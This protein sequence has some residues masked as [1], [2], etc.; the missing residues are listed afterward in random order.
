MD[1]V[2]KKI[3]EF[4]NVNFL[5]IGFAPSS[6]GAGEKVRGKGCGT[7]RSKGGRPVTTPPDGYVCRRCGV[8]G[9]FI[10]H[11]PTNGD[12]NYDVKVA[13]LPTGIPKSMLSAN[14]D[15]GYLLPTGDSAVL[16]PNEAAFEKEIE[17]VPSSSSRSWSVADL[18]PELLCPLC[19]N[20]MRDAVLSGRCCFKS[21]CFGCIRDFLLGSRLKCSCGAQDMLVDYLI[22][23]LTLRKTISRFLE[24]GPGYSSGSSSG[25]RRE[26]TTSLSLQVQDKSSS[27]SRISSISALSHHQSCNNKELEIPLC[28]SVAQ[29][30]TTNSLKQGT[31]RARTDEKSN[32]VCDDR[33]ATSSALNPRLSKQEARPTKKP[34]DEVCGATA[35]SGLKTANKKPMSPGGLDATAAAGGVPEQ[36]MVVAG[37]LLGKKKRKIEMGRSCQEAAASESYGNYYHHMMPAAAFGAYNPYWPGYE[38]YYPA[39]AHFAAHNYFHY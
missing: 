22:P 24:C 33:Q 20:V 38:A 36:N 15:G 11:C 18:P 26:K 5:E 25:S 39:D 17:G 35:S 32:D 1:D 8:A 27:S 19:K 13:R 23:N 7:G 4:V 2:E 10:Q 12:P 3:A 6:G 21:F 28:P 31:K 16:V 30:D 14:P 37:G 34:V 29:E 9:H